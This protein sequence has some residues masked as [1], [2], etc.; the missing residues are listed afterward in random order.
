MIYKKKT[1]KILE[2]IIFNTKWL[3]IPF[4]LIL[5][6]AL[7]VYTYFDVKEFIEYIFRLGH[8]DKESAMLT[9]VELI[10]I[11]MIANLGKMI[12]TGSYNSFISKAHGVE[13][14][15]VSSGMLKVKMATSLVGVTAIGLLSKSID[16]HKVE[17][18]TLYKLAF[19]HGVFLLSAIVLSVVDFLHLKSE[20]YEVHESISHANGKQ[21][22]SEHGEKAG[23]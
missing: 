1:I 17:W 8:I 5:A 7:A 13:G 23:V 3:L 10:D 12:I 2:D 20:T 22:Q 11:T 14:E 9:F 4:Y 15:N 21:L 19:V 18:D 6:M 16:I